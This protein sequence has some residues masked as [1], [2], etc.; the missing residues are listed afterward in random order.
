MV[1]QRKTKTAVW[2][3]LLAVSAVTPFG[4]AEAAGGQSQKAAFKEAMEMALPLSPD[5]IKE[6]RKRADQYE[7]ASAYLPA[8]R[9]GGVRDIHLMPGASVPPLYTVGGFLTTILFYD[10]EGNPLMVG[11]PG[12]KVGNKDA[13]ELNAYNNVVQ[14]NVFSQAYQASNLTVPLDG[15]PFPAVFV[16]NSVKKADEGR[17]DQVVK[18]FVH[19]GAGKRVPDIQDENN[20]SALMQLVTGF[21][22][23]G[24]TPL[25]VTKTEVASLDDPGTKLATRGDF[26]RFYREDA[27]GKTYIVLSN[28]FRLARTYDLL[29]KQT[30]P[31]GSTGYIAPASNAAIYTVTD[32]NRI[33]YITIDRGY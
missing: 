21:S 18:V 20:V 2:A 33:F 28:G 19:T 29:G 26:A 8:P 4:Y 10:S 23:Q 3:L 30:G 16:L 7:R 25:T 9:A 22:I 31:D 15:L 32:N 17:L 27:T 5:E 14:V 24:F 13:Y 11:A 6:A 1:I 12:A